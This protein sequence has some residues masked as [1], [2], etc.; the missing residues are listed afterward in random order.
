ML[1]HIK[2][3]DWIMIGS[4]IFISI[5]GLISLFSSSSL[6]GY[7]NFKK[8]IVF[9]V[10]GLVLMFLLSFFDWKV[11]RTSPY[12]IL[13]IYSICI[14]A[15]IGLLLFAPAIRGVRGWYRI[16]GIS[17][18]PIEA[19]KLIL[20]ILIS[21]YF[22]MRHI[23]M[24]NF[25]HVIVS[26]IYFGVPCLLIFLQPDLGSVFVLLF[27]WIGML[28]VSG[29]KWRHFLVII[30][31]GALLCTAGWSFF[32]QDY[33]KERII[34]YMEPQLEPLGVGWNRNQALITV[35][36]GGLI[37]KGIGEGSQT[38]YG[39]L[40]EPGTDFIFSSIIEEMGLIGA[41]I[42]MSLFFVLIYRILKI[43]KQAKTNFARLFSSG[44]VILLVSQIF[45]HVGMNLGLLPIIGIS[46]PFVSY[47]GSNLIFSYIGLGIIQS[48]KVNV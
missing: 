37:G 48:L 23:E 47:G 43:A 29:I 21:K 11:F 9:L 7:I 36:S 40:P 46:L 20:I 30:I 25:K 19:T 32:L 13:A 1:T 26:A 41:S 34:N 14:I 28:L 27:L 45:I 39:F 5:I 4:A 31:G 24:Y 33:Q 10:L 2:K 8:Q 16:G 35:G 6:E 18:D 44:F 3:L 42:L 22:S 15:L 17:I 12:L 38:K